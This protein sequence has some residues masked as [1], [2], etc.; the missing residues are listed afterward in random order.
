MAKVKTR[1][2][3]PWRNLASNWLQG[4]ETQR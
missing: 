4:T 1:C 2:F 3:L